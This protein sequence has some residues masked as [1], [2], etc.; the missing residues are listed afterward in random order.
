MSRSVTSAWICGCI[1]NCNKVWS[2]RSDMLPQILPLLL[3]V[4]GVSSPV[5]DRFAPYRGQ[6]VLGVDVH[7]P[8]GNDP[9][10]LRALIDIQPGYLLAQ[11][12][13][14]S[15]IKRLYALGRFAQVEVYAERLSGVVVLHFLVHP[16]KRF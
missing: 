14:E 6:P 15:A 11:G 10:E 12:D 5:L 8:P 16:L 13:V 9:N 3:A 2:G 4:A 7:A 1:G